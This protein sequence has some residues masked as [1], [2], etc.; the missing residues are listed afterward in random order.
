MDTRARRER[1]G[2]TV[3][4]LR[5]VFRFADRRYLVVQFYKTFTDRNLT[6]NR[7]HSIELKHKHSADENDNE[8]ILWTVGEARSVFELYQYCLFVAP[9]MEWQ[10]RGGV[11]RFVRAKIERQRTREEA[12]RMD[13]HTGEQN[14]TEQTTTGS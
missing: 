4:S 11:F 13:A 7:A 14:R 6:L 3:L 1:E 8:V 2:K 10:R 12:C 9:L 5:V